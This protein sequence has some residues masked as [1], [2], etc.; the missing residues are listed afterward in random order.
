MFHVCLDFCVV[1]SVGG[2]VNICSLVCVVCFFVS[3]VWVLF[4]VLCCNVVC[5]CSVVMFVSYVMRVVGVVPLWIVCVFC[6]VLVSVLYPVAIRSA[7]FC[8]ICSLCLKLFMGSVMVSI[9]SAS[10]VLYSAVSGM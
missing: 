8:V 6:C 2:C 4:V 5:V 3:C 9:C 10:Y 7:V 1:Y